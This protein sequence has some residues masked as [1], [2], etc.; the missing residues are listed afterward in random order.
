MTKCLPSHGVSV[1]DDI[2]SVVLQVVRRTPKWI[3]RDLESKDPATRVRSE[4]ALTA[5]IVDAIRQ[6]RCAAA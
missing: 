1:T 6:E 2:A 4:E 5:M 3:R